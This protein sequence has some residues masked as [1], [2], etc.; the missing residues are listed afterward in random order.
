MSKTFL[1]LLFILFQFN[2]ALYAWIYPEHRDITVRA[3]EELT[4]ENRIALDKIWLDARKGHEKRLTESIIDVTQT[5]KPRQLDFGAW[6]A[7]AGDHSCSPE[8]M[9]DEI[10]NTDWILKVADIAAQLKIDIKKSKTRSEHINSI[11]DSDI[12]FQRAD[13]MYATRAGS[14][15]SHFL[16][17]RLDPEIDGYQYAFSCLREGAPLNALGVYTFFHISALKKAAALNNNDLSAEDR[18]ALSLSALADEAFAIHFLEDAFAA[19]HVAGTWGDASQRK[20][21]HDYYNEKGLE[22]TTWEGKHIVMMGDAYLR[23]QDME[24][25]AEAVRKSLIQFIS[26]ADSTIHINFSGLDDPSLKRPNGF[27]TC[28]NDFMP[29]IKI[30]DKKLKTFITDVLITTPM[31][32]LATGIGELPRFRS[33]LGI[34]IGVVSAL[35]GVTVNGGFGMMQNEPGAIGGIDIGI[36]FGVGLEGVLN[37]SGDGLI[38]IDAGWRQDGSS[39]MKWGDSPDLLEGGQ[40]TSAI[41]GRDA[42][43]TRFRVPFWLIPGDLI[44]LTPILSLISPKALTN[45]GVQ[46]VNGGLIPWQTGIATPIGRFQFIAGRE[47]G[48][49]FYGIGKDK[50]VLIVPG[51]D[52]SNSETTLNSY[53]SLQLDFPIIEYRP[54]RTFSLDQSSSLVIQLRIGVDIPR[55]NKVLV[56]IDAETPELKSIWYMELAFAFDWRQYIK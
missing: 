10:L 24:V 18:S 12:K 53:K 28:T 47:I 43:I 44:I 13:P 8:N 52:G 55:S 25:T 37:R 3:V 45:I 15:N 20:G 6:P 46:A 33:E 42:V 36:R 39:S 51:D 50:D 41:P 21:T 38:F 32:G 27:N 2:T 17:E 19:G 34:F 11:R 40:I 7:I 29:I 54:F 35:H 49:T 23:P 5:V 4:P 22:I 26:V 1:F 30:E 56:P 9:L 31:P 14:N 48:I 16:L